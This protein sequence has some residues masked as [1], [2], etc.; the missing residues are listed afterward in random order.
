MSRSCLISVVTHATKDILGRQMW[1][2]WSALQS[3][4]S[5][6]AVAFFEESQGR[7]EMT[8]DSHELERG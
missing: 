7:N 3:V 4:T 6:G 8:L 5:G 2:F 1:R